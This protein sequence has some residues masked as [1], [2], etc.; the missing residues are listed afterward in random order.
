[1]T[2]RIRRASTSR[3]QWRRPPEP[4]VIR[5][6]VN[7]SLPAECTYADVIQKIAD[8]CNLRVESLPEQLTRKILR[9]YVVFGS[10]R[11]YLYR[12]VGQP[13]NKNMG[14]TVEDGALQFGDARTK[15]SRFDELVGRLACAAQ[16]TGKGWILPSE[17][18]RIAA[19]VD[20]RGLRPREYVPG[21]AD[22]NQKHPRVALHTFSAALAHRREFRRAVLLRFK[23]AE[24][25]YRKPT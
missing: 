12:I 25:K 13:E 7:F 8:Q 5:D 2:E 15:L 16:R 6:F 18:S 14:W 10:A 4:P 17:Y 24:A 11:E 9:S 21:L 23:R 3:K 20:R 19:E 22:W 1:V